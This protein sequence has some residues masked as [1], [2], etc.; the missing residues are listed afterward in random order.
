MRKVKQY[1]IRKNINSNQNTIS[2]FEGN[3]SLICILYDQSTENL[4]PDLKNQLEKKFNCKS[5]DIK[6]IGTNDSFKHKSSLSYDAFNL[7]GNIKADFF[8]EK[9][10]KGCELLIVYTKKTNLLLEYLQSVISKKLQVGLS[11]N[12]TINNDICIDIEA[13]KINI[14]IN[15]LLD[16]KGKIILSDGKV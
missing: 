11:N 5:K 13:D 6:S 3:Q 16:Y 7:K 9:L 15:E 14:F 2:R 8:D 12:Q 4:I 1:L 10:L